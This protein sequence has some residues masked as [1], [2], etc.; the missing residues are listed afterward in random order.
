MKIELKEI[1]VQELVKGYHDDG[2]GGV[3]GYD[4]RLDIRPPF[5]REFVYKDKQRDAVINTVRRDFPLNVMYWATRDDDT[6]EIID[7]QQRTISIAQYVEGDFSFE[8]LYFHN[9]PKDQQKQFLDYKL[10]VYF[11]SGTD[12]EKLE[13]FRTI[14]IAGE[15]LTDQEL[16]NAVYA[17]SWVSHAKTYFS[18]SNAAAYL[19]GKDYLRGSPIRQEYLETAIEWISDA[20]IEDYMGQHQHDSSAVA[21]WNHF[22][23][24]INWVKSVFEVSRPKM[25]GVDWG[26]LYKT[27]KEDDLDPIV[28]EE[29]TVELI[30]DEDVTNQSG[31]YYYIL[32]REE[33]HLNLRGFSDVIKQRAYEKQEEKCRSCNKR[34]ELSEMEAD[35]ITPWS[36][37]GKTDEE[38]CQVLCQKCNRR[39]SAK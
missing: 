5:Q 16:R 35:H 37:G 33:R 2:E 39:K 11:C 6:F 24:V 13:W 34:F 30:Q 31:I 14:N 18:R 7:G 23:S 28:I 36:K 38:N 22:S 1:T 29:E 3:Q 20:R 8:E 4:S 26:R 27:Y 17:G 12:S 19:L 32:T 9:L 21:L 25:K 15:K 10:M